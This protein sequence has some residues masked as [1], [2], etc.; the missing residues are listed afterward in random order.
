MNPTIVALPAVEVVV[1]NEIIKTEMDNIRG[2][3]V[4]TLKKHLRNSA[5]TLTLRV[6][7]HTAAQRILTRSEQLD[8]M[9]ENN[10]MVEQLQ[11]AFNLVIA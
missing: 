7:E 10:A 5:I 3:I 2:S 11:K 1:P 9:K 6:A 8:L 4:A